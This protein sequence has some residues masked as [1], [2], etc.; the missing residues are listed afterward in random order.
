MAWSVTMTSEPTPKALPVKKEKE[1]I[2]RERHC[3]ENERTRTQT[4]RKLFQKTHLVKQAKD[5]NRHPTKRIYKRQV[6]MC[7]D[8]PYP[9]SSEKSNSKQQ[10]T[11]AH[12]QNG[13]YLQH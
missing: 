9:V 11:I 1:S 13:S 12:L 2:D 7:K 4:E 5:L 10:D 8:V 3:P 6:S